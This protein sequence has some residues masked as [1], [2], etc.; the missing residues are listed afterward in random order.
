MKKII[1]LVGA[2]ALLGV[3]ASAF[4]GSPGWGKIQGDW[5]LTF[6]YKGKDYN[7]HMVIDYLNPATGEFSGTG[8]YIPGPYTWTVA[9]TIDGSNVSFRI[10]YDSSSYYVD[11]VGTIF[12]D[13]TTMS[14][15]WS[16]P[17]QS[18]TWT[19]TASWKNHGEY[20]KQAGDKS[21]AAQSRTGMPVVSKK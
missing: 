6:V 19:G 14:G 8:Y 13:G 20:V 21:A 10:N 11:V 12:N 9:G 18:G 5:D 16:N 15:T 1:A 2:V 17:S 7:H 4:A 3:T